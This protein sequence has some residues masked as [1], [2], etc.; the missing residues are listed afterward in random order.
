MKSGNSG[1]VSIFANIPNIRY[2]CPG[3]HPFILSQK[4]KPVHY[5]HAYKA[6]EY[7]FG[8]LN[9]NTQVL[10]CDEILN[11]IIFDI[12][13][14]GAVTDLIQKCKGKTELVMTGMDASLELIE[15]ADYVT[16]LKQIK[17]PYYHGARARKGIE[18]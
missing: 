1:E 14:K 10:I 15:L 12:L 17:H 4:P 2:R 9:R 13:D 8:A 7:A 11:T 18:S 6:L 3:K 16:Q 5:E